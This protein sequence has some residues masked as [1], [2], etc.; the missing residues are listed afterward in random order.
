M[1]VRFRDPWLNLQKSA[2]RSFGLGILAFLFQGNRSLALMVCR[3]SLLSQPTG[4]RQRQDQ[5]QGGYRWHDSL[6]AQTPIALKRVVPTV[7][8]LMLILTHEG[9]LGA[10]TTPER[11][12]Q[13]WFD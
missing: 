9:N 10:P 4:G 6:H 7:T 2:P 13:G 8:P 3:C 12:S 1:C 11:P 5:H